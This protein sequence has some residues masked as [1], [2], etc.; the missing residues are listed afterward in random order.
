MDSENDS[1]DDST[2]VDSAKSA[3]NNNVSVNYVDKKQAME[4]FKELLREKQVPSKATWEQAL[5]L[6][7]SDSR[8]SSL[9]HLN[10]KKQAFN[11][12]KTQKLKEE[13]EEERKKLKQNKEELE[14]FLQTCEYMNSSIKYRYNRNFRLIS[15]SYCSK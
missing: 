5:K 14:N 10:E 2:H 3:T 8:Y 7:S 13:K 12:Y 4:A 6:I 15:I 1:N 11:A 9:K